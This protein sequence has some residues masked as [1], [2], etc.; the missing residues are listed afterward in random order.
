M[1]AADPN[2]D[3][4]LDRVA[5]GDRVARGR[6]LERHRQKLRMLIAMRLDSRLAARIDPSDVVQESLADADRRLPEYL[7]DR[8]MPFYLWLR[9]LTLQ[10][11][12]DMHRLHVRTQKRSV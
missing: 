7:D 8:P 2:T 6:L 3:Q 10:R 9:E 12:V 4:L 11:L 5:A 1:T